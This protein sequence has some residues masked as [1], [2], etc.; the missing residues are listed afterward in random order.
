VACGLDT[1]LADGGIL[2][3]KLRA[4]VA[5]GETDP[6]GDKALARLSASIADQLESLIA[7]M[8]DCRVLRVYLWIVGYR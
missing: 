2:L 5:A 4:Q 8:R 6:S 7:E 3:V 1:N